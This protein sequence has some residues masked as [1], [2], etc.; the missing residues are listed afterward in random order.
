MVWSELSIGNLQEVDAV[1][2]LAGKAHDLKNSSNPAEYFDVNYG[3]TK[4]LYDLFQESETRKFVYISSVKAAADMVNGVLTEKAQAK[5]VTAY[6]QSK[7]KAEEYIIA[8]AP[9]NRHYYILRPCMIHGPG[10]KGNLNLLYKLVQ[11]GLPY[12]LA[13]FDNNRSFL[14]VDNLCFVIHQLLVR[15]VTSGIYQVADDESLSTIEVVTTMSQVLNRSSKLWKIPK[16]I[17]KGLAKA[18]DAFRLP[19]N[20]ERLQK[21]TENYVV[22]NSKIK[23]A[24]GIRQMPVTA[25]EG[26]SMTVKSFE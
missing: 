20:T 14:S 10:N 21:L 25:I 1:I 3:L 8:N 4:K 19:L 13:A 12:P 24:L 2:H 15:P 17:V 16:S 22:S 18:G 6:G 23:D 26:L 5:P 7:L 11:M 9:E